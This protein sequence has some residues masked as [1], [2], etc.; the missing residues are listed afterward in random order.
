MSF[1]CLSF[2]CNDGCCTLGVRATAAEKKR[3]IESGLGTEA[4]FH[5]TPVHED[6]EEYY[7][8]RADQRGC[9]FLRPERGCRLH[10]HNIKP[11]ICTYFP[12]DLED[13]QEMYELGAMPCFH[14]R[15]F[16]K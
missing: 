10:D 15:T 5:N 3:I 13:A 9:V 1:D 7:Y 14:Q 11:E 6:G 12:Y 2:P 8:T 16:E 4:D